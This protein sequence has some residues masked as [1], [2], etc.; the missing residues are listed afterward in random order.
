[1]AHV[2]PPAWEVFDSNGDITAAYGE[3]AFD[4]AIWY[5]EEDAD[6]FEA[7][8]DVHLAVRKVAGPKKWIHLEVYREMRPQY[9]ATEVNE[10]DDWQEPDDLWR[11]A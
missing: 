8:D 4:A 7:D 2:C 9:R 1:V 10:P 11:S 5:R 3:D 6:D